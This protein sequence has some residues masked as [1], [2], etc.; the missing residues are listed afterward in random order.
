[1]G[2]QAL[3]L[4]LL[5]LEQQ[6]REATVTAGQE[7]IRRS[8][9]ELA[10]A[11]PDVELESITYLQAVWVAAGLTVKM[12]Q[13]E[14]EYRERVLAYGRNRRPGFQLSPQRL[15]Q[16]GRAGQALKA[17]SMAAN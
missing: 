7:R 3:L 6:S 2:A 17:C 13:R 15:A 10:P 1:M 12:T 14:A 16:A 9:S 11:D 8:G 5:R 4:T